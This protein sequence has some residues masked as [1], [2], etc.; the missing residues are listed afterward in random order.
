MRLCCLS[1]FLLVSTRVSLGEVSQVQNVK[2]TVISSTDIHVTW[3][4][5]M[6][7]MQPLQ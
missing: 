6:Q 1:F 2:A 7:A 3:T 4:N 5:Q